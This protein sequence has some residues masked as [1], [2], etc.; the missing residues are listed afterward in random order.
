M[1]LNIVDI[2]STGGGWLKPNDVK[3][4]LAL[5]VEV[6]S[7]E[8]QR[9]TPNGPKDSALCTISVFK[10]RAALD[11][12]S[13][14]VN[15]GTRVEQTLLARDLAGLVGAAT[16]VTVAQIPPTRPGAHPAWVW[17]SVNDASVR[18]AVIKYAEQREAAVTAAAANAPT[19][20]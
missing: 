16:I 18:Q 14:E 3:G 19:F 11:A 8:A 6:N 13:P 10:D 2:P 4:A 9:P 15:T 12:L 1:S 7:Y 17:R 5:L 20:D